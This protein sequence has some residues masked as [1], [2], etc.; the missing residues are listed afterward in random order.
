MERTA[1]T[2][3]STDTLPRRTPGDT[4]GP[5]PAFPEQHAE[6]APIAH[7]LHIPTAPGASLHG[8]EQGYGYTADRIRYELAG[9]GGIQ[10]N[11]AFG[12]AQ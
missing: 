10:A 6:P 11:V 2:T 4:L 7:D 9:Y 5:R 1:S 12:G 8:I 3:S